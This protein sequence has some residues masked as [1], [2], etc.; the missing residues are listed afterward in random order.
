V[1]DVG[2]GE[3][4]VSGEIEVAA[5]VVAVVAVE[6]EVGEVKRLGTM[7]GVELVIVIFGNDGLVLRNEKDNIIVRKK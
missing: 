4:G 3:E 7:I 1:T 2:N 6:T 5:A